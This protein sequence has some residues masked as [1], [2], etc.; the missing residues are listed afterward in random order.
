[1][2][3]S[4]LLHT[5]FLHSRHIQVVQISLQTTPGPPSWKGNLVAPS[6]RGDPQGNSVRS[7]C[8]RQDTDPN[9]QK[10]QKQS[11]TRGTATATARFSLPTFNYCPRGVEAIAVPEAFCQTDIEGEAPLH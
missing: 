9:C 7:S 2:D 10:P 4:V 11:D 8:L 1:M 6:I 5:S 3:T